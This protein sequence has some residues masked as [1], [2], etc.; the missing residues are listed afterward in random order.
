MITF[1]EARNRLQIGEIV[2]T[3]T[4]HRAGLRLR[5]H[6]HASGNINIV[7]GGAFTETLERKRID[8][9]RD[10]VIFKP[11]NTRHAN[12]YSAAGAHCLAVEL[13][14]LRHIGR[15]PR[16]TQSPRARA[17]ATSILAELSEPLIVES[18][19]FELLATMDGSEARA[20]VWLTR[21]RALIEE[22][23]AMSFSLSDLAA[24]LGLTPPHIARAFRRAHGVSVGEYIRRRRV[25]AASRILRTTD[26]PLV[27]VAG[28]TGFTDQ[29]HFTNV[30]RRLIGMTPAAYRRER[31]RACKTSPPDYA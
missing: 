25:A 3:E 21:A 16:V 15:I 23:L 27:E 4:V 12:V 22:R 11:E 20:G 1:G 28:R 24:S 8:C 31:S 18:L 13:P 30:F 17:L 10:T 9:Q 19:V 29:S 14:A 6:D 7:L 26:M 5:P 2:V